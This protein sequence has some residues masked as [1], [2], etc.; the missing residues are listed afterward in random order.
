MADLLVL[1]TVTIL[2]ILL[3]L[4]PPAI[5]AI[6]I[7]LVYRHKKSSSRYQGALMMINVP[8]ASLRI[9]GKIFIVSNDGI[10]SQAQ[11]EL[12]I[13]EAQFDSQARISLLGRFQRVDENTVIE[14][15]NAHRPG[16]VYKIGEEITVT[17][18][19]IQSPVYATV[20]HFLGI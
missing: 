12:G 17:Q 7:L 15:M 6:I 18:S 9:G 11:T 10:G 8:D 4:T 1:D 20:A 3:Q 5:I 19:R 16:R 2:F 14:V 13:V